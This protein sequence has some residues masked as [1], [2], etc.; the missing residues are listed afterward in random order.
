MVAA[1]T[2]GICDRRN[3]VKVHFARQQPKSSADAAP[4]AKC[5]APQDRA[6][7]N[8]RQDGHREPSQRVAVDVVHQDEARRIES[9]FRHVKI[10]PT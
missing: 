3:G 9:H 1:I 8:R 2:A 6:D 5:G 10:L 4:S 7:L